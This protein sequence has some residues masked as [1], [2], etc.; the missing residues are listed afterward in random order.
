MKAF[1][2]HLAGGRLEHGGHPVLAW[3]ASNVM[4][5]LDAAGNMK[6]DRE[7]STE[8]IDGFVAAVMAVG[9]AVADVTEEVEPMVEWV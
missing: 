4:A 6:P 9:R 5:K 2:E 7:K 8:K 1:M 3:H